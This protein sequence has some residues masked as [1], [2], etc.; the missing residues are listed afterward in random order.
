MSLTLFGMDLPTSRKASVEQIMAGR[1][2]G[3]NV[4]NGVAPRRNPAQYSDDAFRRNPIAFK[5]VS[6]VARSVAAID[7]EV[8]N[9]GKI[10]EKGFPL[11]DLLLRPNQMQGQAQFIEA[12]VAYIML[13]GNSYVD[14]FGAFDETGKWKS[15]PFELWTLRPDRMRVTTCPLGVGGY[16]YDFNGQKQNW[17][18]DAVTGKSEILHVKFFN[19][20]EDFYGMSPVEAAAWSIDAHNLAGEWNQA[21]LQNSGRPS[22]NLVY[23]PGDGMP[24]DL[25]KKQRDQI[26]EELNSSVVGTKNAARPMILEGGLTWQQTAMNALDMDWLNGKRESA[27]EIAGVFGVPSMLLGIQGDNTYKNYAEARQAFHEDTVLPVLNF[28]LD[29]LNHWLCPMYG[30]GVSIVANWRDIPAFSSKRESTWAAVAAA[31]WLTTNEKREATGYP[32]L[33]TPDADTILINASL[34]PLGQEPAQDTTDDN[35]GDE[36]PTGSGDNLTDGNDQNGTE[37][38]AA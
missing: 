2:Y 26:R 7:L 6:M 28:F 23:T 36:T 32:E 38:P 12:M 24:A 30:D 37:I 3:Y 9:N 18:R 10:M 34:V 31:D 19:P 11:V 17:P 21:L 15:A 16:V 13:T 4:A 20:C 5:A 33:P 14:A 29:E 8:W 1:Q 27:R 22:G 35:P 25:T